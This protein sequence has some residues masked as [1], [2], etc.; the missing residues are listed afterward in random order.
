[1]CA[2]SNMD[3]P[4]GDI[5]TVACHAASVSSHQIFAV[6]LRVVAVRKEHALVASSLLL[7]ADAARLIEKF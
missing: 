1:M 4:L 6:L 2:S 3:F 7:C 5:E